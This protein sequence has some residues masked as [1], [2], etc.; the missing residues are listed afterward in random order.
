MNQNKIMT[1]LVALA[2]IVFSGCTS[3]EK[4][5]EQ[6]SNNVEKTTESTNEETTLDKISNTTSQ[7]VT[8]V[9]KKGEDISKEIEKTAAP[10]IEK[11]TEAIKQTQEKISNTTVED[12]TS[13]VKETVAPVVENTKKLISKP[14]GK[15]LYT[16]CISCHGQNAQKVALGKSKVIQG[17]DKSQILKALQG[18]K[19]GTYGG[20]M[21]GVMKSQVINMN[22]TELEALSEYIT[23]L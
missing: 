7:A 3:E 14:D 18:Y 16:K 20:A 11:A 10:T 8:D 19:D 13:K 9:A 5:T 15:K 1:I 22:D 4:T 6:A 2:L 17:W 23:T 21:K 12:V